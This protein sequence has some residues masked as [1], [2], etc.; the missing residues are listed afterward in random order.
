MI[1]RKLCILIILS[2]S[3]NLL[4]QLGFE[5]N[6]DIP[7][8][9]GN[10]TLNNAWMG[11]LNHPQ[12]SQIDINDDG[13]EDLFIFDRGSHQIRL[14][15]AS[16][17]A[18]NS[19]QYIYQHLADTLFP[20][21]LRHRAVLLD[22][23]NDG[24]KDI[25]TAGTAGIKVI[26]NTSSTNNHW[27]WEVEKEIIQSDYFDFPQNLFV[28]SIDVPALVDLDHDGDIDILTFNPSGERLEYHRNLSMELFQHSD[29]LIFQLENTC[30][31]KF[32]ES[33]VD[34]SITLNSTHP[35]CGETEM[36]QNE[37][38]RDFRHPG[39]TLL[40]LDLNSDNAKDILIGDVDASN[41]TALISENKPANDQPK[42]IFKD[43]F[44]PSNST[45]V[46][47][48]TM[49]TAYLVDVNLDGN[50]DILFASNV[51][52][53]SENAGG[54]HYYRNFGTNTSP[55]FTLS[56]PNFLHTSIIDAG[57]GS[58]PVFEDVN[59]DGL[60]DLLISSNYE[61]LPSREKVS[62]IHY[63]QNTGTV[64]APVFT[65]VTNDWLN[66]SSK[67]LGLRIVPAFSDLTNNGLRDLVIGT[68]TGDIYYCERN[69]T[70]ANSFSTQIQPLEDEYN[71]PI[72]VQGFATPVFYDLNKNGKEDL[73][74]GQRIGGLMYFSN[75]SQSTTSF[76]LMDDNL[77]QISSSSATTF[78][79]PQFCEINDTTYLLLGSN[80]GRIRLFSNIS[81][82]ETFEE[83]NNAYPDIDVGAQSTLALNKLTSSDDLN[84]I[85]GGELGGVWPFTGKVG[86]TPTVNTEGNTSLT[87]T[88]IYPNPSENGFFTI[89]HD[90][91]IFEI[92]IYN[93]LGKRI[94]HVQCE[95]K[96]C[97]I[98]LSSHQKGMYFL[99]LND[100]RF[101]LVVR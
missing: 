49:P 20:N 4:G 26:K 69:G 7:V 43:V 87:K 12:F 48:T 54:T 74:V 62:R 86:S 45:P 57:R 90:Q 6:S 28:S 75:S 55:N 35:L 100:E 10:D 99:H 65:F 38:S 34:N 98:D 73:I 17:K 76:E 96:N 52:G 56:N 13:L 44:F 70:N 58:I 22:Y 5:F 95:Q 14:F 42:M 33:P 83:V 78:Y 31:G 23:N 79:F 3:L 8:I 36:E 61:Y 91:E 37:N 27:Q 32:T 82:H 29:S 21:D 67:G 15:L 1:K 85:L 81:P 89:Y 84:L 64:D 93:A 97:L 39:T 30:Y 66:L 77:G 68:D 101:K 25:W 50:T 60:L 19:I 63:Y 2:L 18:D 11:G 88:H 80:N 71:S 92:T 41:I 16:P 24:L 59:G 47:I 53:A 9:R 72:S 51:N 94:K 46:N 40:A